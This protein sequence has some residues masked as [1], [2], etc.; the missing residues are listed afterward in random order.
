LDGIFSLAVH[1][2]VYL[3][4]KDCW[5]SSEALAANICTNPARVR[6]VMAQLK[7]A[8]FVFTREGNIGGYRLA[9]DPAALRLDAVADALG[10]RFVSTA[11]H[12]GSDDLGCLVASGMAGIMDG[13]Y[14]DLDRCCRARLAAVTVADLE[15]RI[16]CTAGAPPAGPSAAA[17]GQDAKSG[18]A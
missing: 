13:L 2:L 5:L 6:K 18:G 17:P 15:A 16:F 8:G 3:S 7:R 4:H 1:A 10:V 9:A 14:A 12:S 11:W